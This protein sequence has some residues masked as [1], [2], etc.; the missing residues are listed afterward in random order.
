MST[1]IYWP[2]PSHR[3]AQVRRQLLEGRN[4]RWLSAVRLRCTQ[5][6]RSISCTA[7]PGG[8]RPADLG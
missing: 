6:S 4:R 5:T 2:P 8:S 3:L 1:W 7:I